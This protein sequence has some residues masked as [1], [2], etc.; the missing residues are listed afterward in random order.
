M[1]KIFFYYLN[2]YID[3]LSYNISMESVELAKK[4]RD[5]AFLILI[6]RITNVN[7]S[8]PILFSLIGMIGFAS[9]SIYYSSIDG[10]NS[11]LLEWLFITLSTISTTYFMERLNKI[12]EKIK[13]SNKA[14]SAV[15]NLDKICVDLINLK[16]S[17]SS[18]TQLCSKIE[19]IEGC[20]VNAID[21]W[22]D[23]LPDLKYR[24]LDIIKNKKALY[25]NAP[26][27]EKPKI[28]EEI[29]LLEEKISNTNYGLSNTSGNILIEK[30]G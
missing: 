1:K 12:R 5:N 8:L 20:L 27:E 30:K 16:I 10:K 11:K 23:I 19:M 3:Q 21:E 24:D 29:I 25:A 17:E 15:R 18:N 4:E 26:E 13:M 28:K 7:I 2:L 22:S 6:Y 9:G 14:I